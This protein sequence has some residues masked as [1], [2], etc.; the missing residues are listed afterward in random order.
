MSNI[1]PGRLGSI[2]R[3]GEPPSKEQNRQMPAGARKRRPVL[4]PQVSEPDQEEPEA[5]DSKHE[6]DELA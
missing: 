5:D 6:L 4:N 3:I 1:G 2:S